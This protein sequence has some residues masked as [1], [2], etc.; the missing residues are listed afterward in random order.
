MGLEYRNG[1]YLPAA[2]ERAVERE[3]Q[4]LDDRLFLT[5]EIEGGRQVYRVMCEYAGDHFA[6]VCDWRDEKGQPLPLS[7]SLVELV[8]SLRPR[9]GVAVQESIAANERLQAQVEA[10]SERDI[11]E[12][13]AD[14][15]PRISDKRSA[16]LPRGPHLRRARSGQ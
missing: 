12:I 13:V 3:L 10:D 8:R 5:F 14:M 11:D 2:D 6:P 16:C 1:I 9:G 4:Q 15:A 7:S